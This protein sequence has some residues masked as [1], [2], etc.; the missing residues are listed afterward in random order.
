[1]KEYNLR[2]K[3]RKKEYDRIKAIV[4]RD[5]INERRRYRYKNSTNSKLSTLLRG[6]IK[7]AIGGKKKAGSAI[8]DMGCTVEELKK[9][10]ESKFMPGMTWENHS[11]VGW[12]IDHIKPLAMFDLSSRE[13]FL[14]SCHYTNLQPLWSIEN[15]SKGSRYI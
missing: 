3:E 14:K 5:S 15:T 1:M 11:V 7:D 2:N 12:H 8:L 6:R 9:Y 13:D 4:K 10:L